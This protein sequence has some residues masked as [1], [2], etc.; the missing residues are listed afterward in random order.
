M[1]EKLHFTQEMSLTAHV[2][3]LV[4]NEKKYLNPLR[5]VKDCSKFIELTLMRI[6]F[7]HSIC[8]IHRIILLPLM[9]CFIDLQT[10]QYFRT[11]T[12][13]LAYFQS[14][15]CCC[16]IALTFKCIHNVQNRWGMSVK[17]TYIKVLY[18]GLVLK[19]S[20]MINIA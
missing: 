1:V 14:I 17:I 5:Y 10:G 20:T 12:C 15:L 13:V 19:L 16:S 8:I 4:L 7:A 6:A 11:T 2:P 18:R 3:C 9:V